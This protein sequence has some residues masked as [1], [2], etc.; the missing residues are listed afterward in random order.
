MEAVSKNQK[1]VV[2]KHT[3]GK[4]EQF[5]VSIYLVYQFI[6]RF[7]KELFSASFERKEL[8]KQCY[9]IGV[10]SLPIITLTAFITGI[11]FTKQSRPSLASFGAT[12]WLPSLIA[13][14]VIRA[15][16]PLLTALVMA[17]N[18]GS[19]MGAELGSMKV[20]E[21][22][23]AME[24]SS[25][26]PFKYLVVTRVLATTIMV[27]LL[28]SYF[29]FVGLFGAF[30]NVHANELTSYTSFVDEA[31][32]QIYFIDLSGSLIKSLVYGLTIGFTGCF[33][34]FHAVQGTVGVG[35][36]ANSAVVT[37]MFLIFIEEMILVQVINY[38]R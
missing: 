11:V 1:P 18:V 31:F 17:G 20:T 13:I 8:I 5:L 34:G 28:A 19:N 7:C 12:S 16:A 14:A 21:Q 29:S 3:Q 6:L 25:T 36:A 9:Q 30:L 23:D 2:L 26:E 38:F 4:A 10:K 27:P 35:R 33:K 37:A 22:I 24:V 32:S 15:L